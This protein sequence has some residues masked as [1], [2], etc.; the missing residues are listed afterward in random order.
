MEALWTAGLMAVLMLAFA[1]DAQ[2]K[3]TIGAKLDLT[4]TSAIQ[5]TDQDGARYAQVRAA[6]DLT[7]AGGLTADAPGVVTRFRLKVAA[8]GIE[9]RIQI[10]PLSAVNT[11][12]LGLGIYFVGTKS[13]T[14]DPQLGTREYPVR[15]PIGAG[16]LLGIDILEGLGESLTVVATAGSGGMSADTV[17]AHSDDPPAQPNTD[18][19]YVVGT[20]QALALYNADI[21]PDAD[22]DGFGDETQDACP[23]SPAVQTACPATKPCTALEGKPRKRCLCKHKP[24]KKARKKCLKRLRPKAAKP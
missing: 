6:P 18:A 17:L 15:F 20:P 19:G 11:P 22:G 23:S 9:P 24:Q 16:Q 21:E 10:R 2:G 14:I 12:A 5:D 8:F 7:T 3:E 1:G 13:S 4:P